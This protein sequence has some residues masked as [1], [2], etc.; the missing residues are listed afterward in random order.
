M[1][2][3]LRDNPPAIDRLADNRG[4]GD[5]TPRLWIAQSRD[6]GTGRVLS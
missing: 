1:I 2:Y 5:F 3:K 6:A 4:G